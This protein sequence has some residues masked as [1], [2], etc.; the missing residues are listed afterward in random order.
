MSQL[1]I[2][3]GLFVVC[4]AIG[5]LLF[6]RSPGHARRAGALSATMQNLSGILVGGIMLITGIL[7]LM[8]I[9]MAIATWSVFLALG[10]SSNAKQAGGTDLR[11]TASNWGDK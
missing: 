10:N 5:L 8:V 6:R 4:L 11:A 3:G 1:L 7:P 2:I 9:G